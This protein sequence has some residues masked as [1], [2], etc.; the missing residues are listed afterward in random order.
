M[1][2][3]VM[4]VL[5]RTN[6]RNHIGINM[7]FHCILEIKRAECQAMQ[8]NGALVPLLRALVQDHGFPAGVVAPAMMKSRAAA[9]PFLVRKRIA[10]CPRIMTRPRSS[11]GG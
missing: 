8:V 4:D 7:V 6:L 1:F 5:M 2:F 3:R 10:M 11:P 9:T